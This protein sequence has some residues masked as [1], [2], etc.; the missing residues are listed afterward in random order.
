MK[1]KP[2][3]RIRSPKYPTRLEVLQR[4]DLLRK[5]M[6]PAW[7]KLAET[8]GAVGMLLV[9]NNYVLAGEKGANT[10]PQKHA[11]VAPIFTHGEGRAATG[12]EVVNP[13]VFLSEQDAMQVIREEMKKA[14][15]V[16]SEEKVAMPE[17]RIEKSHEEYSVT[18]REYKSKTVHDADIAPLQ[19][20]GFDPKKNVAVEFVNERDYFD[21]G[22]PRSL[23]TVQQWDFKGVAGSVTRKVEQ[24]GRDLYFGAFYEPATRMSAEDEKDFVNQVPLIT[25]NRKADD[26]NDQESMRRD[27]EK[28]YA[29]AT[30]N[31]RAEAKRLLRLQVLDFIQWLK[32]Q[33]VI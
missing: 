32:A 20:S 14:G 24:D 31:A 30:I 29:D 22:G 9:M 18:N 6:P 8:T 28:I 27:L 13:P 12:C 11:V 19:L 21:L 2:V 4:P 3:S 10:L 16:L 26:K 17:V 15:I 25:S 5:H 23:S 7:R 1:T 33:G